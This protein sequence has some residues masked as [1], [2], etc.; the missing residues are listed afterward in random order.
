MLDKAKPADSVAANITKN[1]DFGGSVTTG[2]IYT[3][4]CYDANGNLK[5][6]DEFHNLVTNVG[7]KDI[8]EKY[9]SGSAYTAAWYIGLVNATPTFA[10]G[11]TAASHAG[12]TE[13]TA[14]TQTTRPPLSFGA[15]T[16]ANPS[17]ITATAAVFTM[18]ATAT[19]AGA[20]VISNNT[21]AGTTGTLFSEGTFT[22]GSK[23]VASGDTLNITYS[24]STAG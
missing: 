16:T 17:V 18:N 7:L 8:N 19:I 5:W 1:S 3:V 20:F 13:N 11:D 15:S 23:S 24:L 22:G 10:G 21:K 12:W 14:Y 9:L 4:E 6:E 2:G